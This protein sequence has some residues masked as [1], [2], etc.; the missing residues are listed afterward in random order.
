M[1]QDKPLRADARRNRDQILA[2][3]HA[4]FLQHGPEVPLDQIAVR[5]GVGNATLYRHFPTRE[6]LVE[7]LVADNMRR[8]GAA[9]TEA[10]KD[11]E[12]REALRRFATEVVEHQ[13]TAMLP[14]LGGQ[15]EAGRS[16]AQART[17]IVD[18]VRALTTAAHDAGALRP[19][20]EAEDLLLF[21]SVVTRPLPSVPDELNAALRD[22]MLGTLLDGLQA[23]EPTRLPGAPIEIEQI[24]DNLTAVQRWHGD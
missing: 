9:A 17:E 1:S 7:H 8:V 3:A 20:V 23:G 24:D 22:R 6:A 21:L 2:A 4:L 13:T 5:A 14:I 18:A 15:V 16:F 11:A 12:P 10:M 19:D